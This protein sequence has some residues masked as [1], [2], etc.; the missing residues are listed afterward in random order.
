M[1]KSSTLKF[2]VLAIACLTTASC[3][4]RTVLSTADDLDAVLKTIPVGES[5]YV[6]L[7]GKLQ[8]YSGSFPKGKGLSELSVGSRTLLIRSTAIHKDREAPYLNKTVS[9]RFKI[10]HF[11]LPDSHPASQIAGHWITEISDLESR[12]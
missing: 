1:V 10:S 11:P 7:V 4:T 6:Q 3:A 8:P 9:A 5:R 12:E 2:T